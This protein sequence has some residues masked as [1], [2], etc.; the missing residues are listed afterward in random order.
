MR[1]PTGPTRAGPVGIVAENPTAAKG[2]RSRTMLV[3][4]E[5]I[6]GKAMKGAIP[7]DGRS[8]DSTEP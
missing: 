3:L 7:W 8:R 5:I 1:F 2:M 6:H 4:V